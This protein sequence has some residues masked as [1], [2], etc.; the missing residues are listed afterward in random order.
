[1]NVAGLPTAVAVMASLLLPATASATGCGTP[2]HVAWP[3]DRAPLS[4]S[5]SGRASGLI[6]EY[7]TLMATQRP[8]HLLPLPAGSLDRDGPPPGTQAL[9]GWPRAQLPPGWVAS[10]PYLQLPQVIVRREGASPVMGLEDLR[11]RT[12]ASPDRLPLQGLL[13]DQAP[14]AQLLP[15][16]SLDDALPLLG[17]GLIDAVVANLGD[18]EAALRRYQGDALV[19]AAPAGF[20]DAL[21]LATLPG[22]ADAIAGFE[23]ALSQLTDS[24][25]DQI[26]AAWLPDL[27]R[28][29]SSSSPLRWLVPAS[30]ILLALALV[31]AYG[32]W[33]VHRESVRRRAVEQRL[34]EVTSNLP[35]VV[36]QAR[37][38]AGGHYSFPQ[39]AGDVQALFGISVETARI[40]QQR[41]LA[42]VH[43]DDRSRLMDAVDAA[44]LAGGPIDVTF[45]T[46][47]P[48]GWRWGRSHGRPMRCTGGDIEWNGYWMDVSEVQSRT[49]A[50]AEARREA[51]QVAQA[52]AHFLAT[53]SH[54]IR[55]PMS[56]LLGMLERLAGS[57]LEARQLQVL[58]TVGDAARMLRQILDDVLHSQRLQAVPLQLRPTDLAALVRAVQQLLMP[59]AASRGLHLQVVVDPAVQQGSLA[60]GL[61]LRQILFNLAGNALKFTLHGHVELQVQVLGQRD[62][63]QRLRLQ[64]SD[65]GVGIS[66]ERQQAVFAA[67]TQAEGST[68]RRFGGTG[69]GLAICRD[70]AASM[71]AQLQLRSTPG[72]GTTVWL[73]LDLDAC[74]VP[75]DASPMAGKDA[76]PLPA[77][78]VLV[79]EDH[80]TNLYLLEQRLSALGL[81]VHACADGRQALDA[82]QAQ[83]F[84]LVITDCHMPHVDGFALARAIRDDTCP[85]RA[86]VPVIALTASVLDSTRETCRAAGIDHFLAKPVEPHELRALLVALL[87]PD[88][89]RQ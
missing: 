30:L 83:P 25:R 87:A 4:S 7:L 31:H 52:K 24:E 88:S 18:V 51:E 15:P 77:A 67:Y 32:Y 82:W 26:R 13:A 14:G 74:E 65:S 45:R 11:G 29:P 42:A 86:Q 21:V 68:T 3:S 22:C 12:V 20:D 53:M 72:E 70:L 79:A 43:P 85:V 76:W 34:Q 2:L 54:E 75:V 1:M 27:P 73:E 64:V 59:V 61:R 23:R 35:A 55:T 37:R 8:L 60:D 58:A 71:G 38:S 89:V 69:L 6:A 80:P 63:G 44:A 39:I 9:L 28:K 62:G 50:L 5:E 41:L 56:T 40:D 19:I 33:R 10:A 49:R 78:R 48:H 57:R 16:A 47:S 17:S 84:D 36:Y 46:R 66:A 81:Q